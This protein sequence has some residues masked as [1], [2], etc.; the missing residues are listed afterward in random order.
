MQV[1]CSTNGEVLSIA[2][3]KNRIISGHLDGTIKVSPFFPPILRNQYSHLCEQPET[4]I[5]NHHKI[6]GSLCDFLG[7]IFTLLFSMF[8]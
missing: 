8:S 7:L 2:R 6:Q 3:F 4:N 5:R 1:D